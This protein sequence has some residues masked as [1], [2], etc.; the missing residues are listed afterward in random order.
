[1]KRRIRSRGFIPG[2]DVDVAANVRA[3]RVRPRMN[4]RFLDDGKIALFVKVG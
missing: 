3:V 2:R 1:M 4:P